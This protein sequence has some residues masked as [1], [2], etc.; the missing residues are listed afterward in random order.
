MYICVCLQPAFHLR[1]ISNILFY[2]LAYLGTNSGSGDGV[3][4]SGIMPVVHTPKLKS[5]RS[6]VPIHNPD[7][8]RKLN[9]LLELNEILFVSFCIHFVVDMCDEGITISNFIMF[10]LE[11]VTSLILRGSKDS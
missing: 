6:L 3:Q 10:Q 8:M 9:E 7:E 11:H 4:V 1:N 2:Y 5:I